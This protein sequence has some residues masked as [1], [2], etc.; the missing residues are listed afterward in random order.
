MGPHAQCWFERGGTRRDTMDRRR[1]LLGAGGAAIGGSALLGSGAFTRVE[2]QRAVTIQVAEDPDAYLGMQGCPDSP[3]QSYT[4]IDDQGHLEVDMTD[5]NPTDADGEGINSDS[6]S[7]FDDVFQICNNG[8]QFACI[9]I[10]DQDD[11]PIYEETGERRVEFYT[12][13]STAATTLND[14]SDQSI[15]G[16]ANSVGLSPGQCV[17]VGIATVSKGLSNGTQLLDILDNEVTI[18]ADANG[19]CENQLPACENLD[20]EYRC[21]V[22]QEASENEFQRL[23][24]TFLIE[25]SGPGT[26]FELAVA[27]SPGSW[28]DGIPIAANG[29]REFV[30]DAS[31]PYSALV[32]WEP[33]DPDCTDLLNLQTWEEYKE[34]E[35][36][37]NLTE[38][39]ETFGTSGP[40]ADAPTNRPDDFVVQVRDIP[41]EQDTDGGDRV[42]PDERIPGDQY[43]DMS[44]DSEEVGWITCTKFNQQN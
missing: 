20:A 38:W 34:E 25:N 8:K 26:E 43:P 13:T 3:N 1:F 40:P 32:F 15:I 39:Y 31:F 33:E 19:N 10:A 14:L 29:T 6:R 44:A 5:A 11:W 17:C 37:A 2:S 36:I 28:D 18:S 42:G 24:T 27:D 21:T 12:G 4:N 41:E 16:E 22:Y 7:Y 35:G 23:G 30:A 9:S